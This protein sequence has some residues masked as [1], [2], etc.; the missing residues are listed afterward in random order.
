M[1]PA[2]RRL[3]ARLTEAPSEARYEAVLA[4]LRSCVL[5][6]GGFALLLAARHGDDLT[7]PFLANVA[8]AVV[9]VVL[10]ARFSRMSDAAMARAWGRWSTLADV[11]AY[12]G[13]SVAF[14]DRPGAGSVYG[15]FV[16]LIG[17][18]RYG[19]KGVL[20]TV[21]PVGITAVL[22][23]QLDLTGA[24]TGTADVVVLC[25][26]FSAPAVVIRSVVMR[27]GARVRQAEEQFSAAFEHAPIG[28]ALLDD[29][30]RVLQANRALG[31]LVG[32]EP[33]ELIGRSLDELADEADRRTLRRALR[34]LQSGA[35]RESVEVRFHHADGGVRWGHVHVATI[36]GS[37]SRAARVVVQI[38][39]VS[40]RKRSEELLTHAAAHDALTDLPN[41]TLLISQLEAALSRGR[42]VGVLFLDLDRFKVV[43]DGLGHAAGDQLLVQ[44]AHRL[45]DVMRPDDVVARQGGDE[46]VVLCLGADADIAMAVAARVIEALHQP[47]STLNGGEV[48]VG[49]SI[50]VALGGPGSQAE[51]VLRDADTAM[52]AAKALGG[53][54]ARLFTPELR[55]A[56]VL[57]HELE[58]DLRAAVRNDQLSLVYQPVVDLRLGRVTG[59]EALVRWSHPQRGVVAP[60]DFIPVAEQ[61][62]LINELGDW[63]LAR[64][65]RDA[66]GWTSP[67]GG[68][69][70]SVSVNVSL[71]QLTSVGL[72]GRV[73]ELLADTGFD[74]GRLCLEVTE[75]ALA[76]DVV[77]VID[78][79]ESLR[80]VGVR[81]SIDD[82]GTGH[83]SLTYLARFPVDQVKVDQSFV[84]GLGIDAGS[85][86]IVGGVIAMA[87]TFD[88]RVVAE[89]VE[90]ESQ[91]AILAELGADAVQGFF[92][93]RPTPQDQLSFH[94]SGPA[95][96]ALLPRPRE[97]EPVLA[98][99]VELPLDE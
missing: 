98:P 65:L 67:E 45:R 63:V 23:P 28:K 77:Q 9:S 76:S 14:H 89:G 84:A 66:A 94:L 38:E 54:R 87:H 5:V 70:P 1:H 2:P 37:G 57:V 68:V 91:L 58:T 12:A 62:D 88:L 74:P 44:V 7:G 83:A 99:P 90:T 51:L 55:E 47:I 92:T 17:P 35:D 69:A 97:E 33:T 53:G 39:N 40:E 48:V 60:Q 56:V 31:V 8:L 11:L 79:L 6:G 3:L 82:F 80:D 49:A 43:N 16:L 59:C 73:A 85:A 10:A 24:T 71:R 96:R 41:R 46:F 32:E 13:Y 36:Q 81:L 95:A 78:A 30:L 50:G 29:D 64:A 4:L 20:A 22:W 25:A 72:A 75:T 19:G 18:I 61:S 15:V 93:A 52:Y 42:Q 27:G 26:I 34:G 21:V 86:A